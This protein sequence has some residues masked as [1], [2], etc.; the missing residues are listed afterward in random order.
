MEKTI[1]PKITNFLWSNYLFGKT[2]VYPK[3]TISS[4]KPAEEI[5]KRWHDPDRLLRIKNFEPLLPSDIYSLGLLFWEIAWCK[6][7]NLPFKDVPIK[8]LYDHLRNDNHET[9]P[10]IP[11]EYQRWAR[12]ISK[13]WQ[14]KSDDW[15]NIMTVES[16]MQKLL[17]I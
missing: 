13:M 11:E 1:I 17:F 16:T 6:A 2:S 10:R 8:K 7:D 14:F 5:W 9:L 4:E 15:Y 3:T 12:L